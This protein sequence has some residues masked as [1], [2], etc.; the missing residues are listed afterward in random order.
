MEMNHLKS[1][2][3]NNSCKKIWSLPLKLTMTKFAK[4]IIMM[5]NLTI[6]L[7]RKFLKKV[8]HKQLK[9]LWSRRARWST[10]L[11]QKWSQSQWKWDLRLLRLHVSGVHR[12]PL[13][14]CRWHL[15]KSS[16]KSL[17]NV[18]R[19]KSRLRH[20]SHTF[21]APKSLSWTLSLYSRI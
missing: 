10:L 16:K 12:S 1:C 5:L 3:L 8:S 13:K 6:K 4:K 20:K 15:N 19:L 7:C 17:R 21:W 9:W 18:I 2:L 14:S 11:S